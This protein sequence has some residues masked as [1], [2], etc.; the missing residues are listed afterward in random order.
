MDI[1][2]ELTDSVLAIKSDAKL[3]EAFIK[4]LRVGTYSQQTRV[5]KISEAIHA[6]HPPQKIVHL[7][8]LLKDDK[9]ANLVY[10]ELIK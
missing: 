10:L 2:S 3:K 7:L 4:I 9:F 1:Y 6:H 8:K 5:E